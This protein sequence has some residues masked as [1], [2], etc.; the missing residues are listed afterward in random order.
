MAKKVNNPA[1][2]KDSAKKVETPKEESVESV[3]D[4]VV[5]STKVVPATDKDAKKAT[6]K[7]EKEAKKTQK[8]TQKAKK[9]VKQPL[10]TE[11]KASVITAK[12]TPRKARL[13][14]DLVR[15][16]DVNEALQILSVTNKRASSI[17]SK[18]LKSAKANAVNNFGMDENNLYVA[19]IQASDSL[20]MKR[21]LPRAKGSASGMLKRF[22]NIY[23]TLKVRG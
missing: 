14:I 22:S 16:K 11:A 1:E 23:V 17:V 18:L 6:K 5:D 13:V 21:Y 2:V 10:R 20:K 3:I 4:Q 7:A 9:E 12:V 19:E 8:A 15:G